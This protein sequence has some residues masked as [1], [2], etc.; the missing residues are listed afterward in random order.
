[1]EITLTKTRIAPLSVLYH[2]RKN[3]AM[4]HAS[5]HIL[6]KSHPNIAFAGYSLI[7]GFWIY[8]QTELQDIQKAVEMA[9]ARLKNGERQLAVHPNCGT[10]IAVTGLCTAASS[11]LALMAESDEDSSFSRFSALTSAGL[12]GALIGRPL[13]PAVQKHITTDANVADLSIVGINCKSF[14]G[15]PVFFIETELI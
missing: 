9:Q 3:H 13:G 8:G 2:I 11:S 6:T 10:N 1:M 15:T 5:I 12:I 4:E 14:H 7:K